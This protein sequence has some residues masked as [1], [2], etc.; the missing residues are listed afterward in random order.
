MDRRKAIAGMAAGAAVVT[1]AALGLPGNKT[2][3]PTL[4]EECALPA[5]GPFS[6]YFPNVALYTHEGQR[7]LFYDD[8]LRGKT[9]MINCMSVAHDAVY[10]TIDNLL[11]VQQALGDRVG[12]DVFM[13]SLSV[14][15]END[16]PEVLRA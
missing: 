9:V 11:K 15:T 1:G 7:A 8:L 3:P 14:D 16:T 6:D 4:V 12:R 5:R 2:S 10:P 13:Y